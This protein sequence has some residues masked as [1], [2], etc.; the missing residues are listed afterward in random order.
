MV[1]VDS[2]A[3]LAA[4]TADAAGAV[5][6]ALMSCFDVTLTFAVAT[7]STVATFVRVYLPGRG[8]YVPVFRHVQPLLV[9]I[10]FQA[11]IA[12]YLVSPFLSKRRRIS[13]QIQ[14]KHQVSMMLKNSST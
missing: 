8:C 6:V 1:S 13:Q 10:P 5:A 4:G 12:L 14:K 2:V 7:M 3:E 11:S 9:L